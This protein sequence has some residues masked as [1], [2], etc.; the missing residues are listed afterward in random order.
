MK[1][2][3]LT[4]LAC[5]LAAAPCHAQQTKATPATVEELFKVMKLDAMMSALWKQMDGM[6]DGM[7]QKALAG[8]NL[9]PEALAKS[10]EMSAKMM[11]AMK[12][13]LSPE[14]LREMYIAIYTDV[15]T[16]EELR[17]I[18]DFYKT[19]AGQALVD[20]QPLVMQKSMALMQEKMGAIM[21][22]IQAI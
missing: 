19:P 14:K 6:M 22:K 2:L 11:S 4:I 16:E 8:K 9:P 13:E 15:F 12:D 17:A 5:A 20:K 18:I 3:L 1:T 21:P 7:M 10:K